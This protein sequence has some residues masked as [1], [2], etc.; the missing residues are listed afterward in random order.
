MKK[1]II[2]A[3]A[4]VATLAVM[5][6]CGNK[7]TPTTTT[8]A[9]T[10]AA[11]TTESSAET[12]T[13][14]TTAEPTAVPRKIQPTPTPTPIPGLTEKNTTCDTELDLQECYNDKYDSDGNLVFSRYWWSGDSDQGQEETFEYKDGLCIRSEGKRN[15]RDETEWVTDYTYDDAGRLLTKTVHEYMLADNGM[16]GKD[17]LEME[18]VTT[19]TYDDDGFI[20]DE[21][22]STKVIAGDPWYQDSH[23][24]YEYD[25]DGYLLSKKTYIISK[26]QDELQESI[27]YTCNEDGSIATE[28]IFYY[29]HDTTYHRQR[30]YDYNDDGSINWIMYMQN[31]EDPESACSKY[32]TYDD[33]G[34]LTQIETI[35]LDGSAYLTVYE[36]TF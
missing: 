34:L 18:T 3:F 27:D 10:S 15:G 5:T 22:E 4:A 6:A 25:A 13:E 2:I 32:Y 28:D 24:V 17:K 14:A 35:Y 19:Y 9:M 16:G 12:T 36:Y 11:T 7:D 8:A 30:M 20:L 26:G 29:W 31:V 21:L 1:G 33:K 23:I